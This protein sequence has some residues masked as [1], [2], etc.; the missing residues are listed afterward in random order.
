MRILNVVPSLSPL[1]G[2]TTSSV[3]TMASALAEQGITCEFAAS[4]DNG[5]GRK[6]A[7]DAPERGDNARHYFTKVCD[8]YIFTPSFGPWLEQNITRYDFLHIHGLFSHMDVVAGRVARRVGLP[9]AITPHGMVNHYGMQRKRLKKLLSFHLF[10]KQLLNNAAFVQMTSK[11]EA[12]DFSELGISARTKL[13][14]LA[15]SPMPTTDP[16]IFLTRFP[17]LR[18]K[19]L[20]LF[21]GRLDP[22]KNVES[23]IDGFA[24]AL[25]IHP[26]IRLVV[27]GTGTEAYYMQLVER[28]RRAGVV[29]EVIWV[30]QVEGEMK[31]SVFAASRLFVLP[32]L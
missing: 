20:I 7:L 8:L 31:A 4:D 21:M 12:R 14:P 18:G 11:E 19:R 28:V 1:H 13:I 3:L 29:G 23:L 2:G 24:M 15:V 27:C 25:K 22:I 5:R 17:L 16:E 10:E 26:D 9:Y 6:L 32:S 30:G